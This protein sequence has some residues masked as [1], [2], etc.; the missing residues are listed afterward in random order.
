[1]PDGRLRLSI[2]DHTPVSSG[3]PL[4]DAFWHSTK[5]AQLAERTG[6]ERYWVAEHHNM[7]WLAGSTPAV[8]AA[9]VAAQTSTLRVGTGGLMLSN[10]SPLS[11][12]E[13]M[14]LLEVLHPGRIDLGLGR[15]SGANEITTHAL[16][17][18]RKEFGQSF[19]ELLAFFRGDFPDGHPYGSI[20]A[21][22]GRDNMP[23]IWLLGSG[24]YSAQLAGSLGLPFAHG[25]HFVG[26][27]SVQAI[28][29]Y[30][31]A[32]RPSET[33]EEPYAVVSVGAIC[34][35]TD[36]LAQR[37]HNAARISMVRA[38]SG[39]PGP[40]LSPEESEANPDG[41]RAP[42]QDDYVSE[43]LSHHIVGSPTTVKAGLEDLAKR[44]G[45]NEIMIATIMHGYENRLRS[46]ELTAEACLAGNPA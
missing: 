37:Y 10:Y 5:L 23:A 35:E 20:I 11:T 18:N 28:E 41:P 1:M 44:T 26:S 21:T 22:P 42:G 7:P 19:A 4:G 29:T 13:Q 32:F 16:Q 33:L 27:N 38:M 46:Y 43:V 12:V 9:H 34:M 24:S 15:S 31:Q 25:G 8:L 17:P 6:Y 14:G 2:L 30:H 36:E 3:S 39:E 40:L 45:A